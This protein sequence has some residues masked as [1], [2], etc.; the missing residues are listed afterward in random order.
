MKRDIGGLQMKTD[1]GGLEMRWRGTLG[2]PEME[3][4]IGGPE[5]VKRLKEMK[6]KI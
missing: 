6:R 4:D 2:G 3:K 5:T 1:I